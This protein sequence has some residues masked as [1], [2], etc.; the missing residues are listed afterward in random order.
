MAVIRNLELA[1][2]R[3]LPPG[4]PHQASPVCV[5]GDELKNELF[6]NSNA[7]GEWVR[8]GDRRFRVIGVLKGGGVSMGIDLDDMAFIPVASA[9]ALFDSSSL[10]RI[11]TETRSPTVIP[12]A[13]ENIRTIIRERHENE[14]DVTLIAQDSV[15]ATFDKVLLSLTLGISGIAAISLGVAGILIMNIMLVSVSQRTE[16]IGLLKALGA[17]ASQIRS[18]F[19]TE[20]FLLSCLG[21]LVGLLLGLV[22]TEL[23]HYLYPQFPIAAPMW[24]MVTAVGV[25]LVTGLIFG[26]L[27]AI[28]ASRLDPVNALAGR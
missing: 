19:I 22:L 8:I 1:Q 6:G 2:G 4:D 5:I 12:Q 23:L 7:L 20:A 9:Q 27:P 28:R 14:D 18:L 24:A 26:V 13:S 16:E 15:I 11:L 10:F 17:P 25:A 3:F 21:S